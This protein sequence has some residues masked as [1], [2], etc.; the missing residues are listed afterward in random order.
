MQTPNTTAPDRPWGSNQEPS[1]VLQNKIHQI[2]ACL[3]TLLF[4]GVDE[5]GYIFLSEVV[6]PSHDSCKCEIRQKKKLIIN[7][8]IWK[9][10]VIF[11]IPNC[12]F[13]HTC[14]LVW[15]SSYYYKTFLI[16]L[17]KNSKKLKLNKTLKFSLSFFIL[18]LCWFKVHLSK[19]YFFLS[20]FGKKESFVFHNPPFLIRVVPFVVR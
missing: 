4:L 10:L 5:I 15:L 7:I 3:R 14:V 1:V 11:G 8:N 13:G 6:G 2:D 12:K 9:C 19:I 17:K 20:M 18:T 16:C